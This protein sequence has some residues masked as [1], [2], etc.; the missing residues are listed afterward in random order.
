MNCASELLDS[1]RA[2]M[3]AGPDP[4]SLVG[5]SVRRGFETYR[6]L[7]YDPERDEFEVEDPRG[8]KRK[9]SRAELHWKTVQVLEPV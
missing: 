3:P 9:M 7:A 5:I 6:V 2:L 4:G 8:K 1:L